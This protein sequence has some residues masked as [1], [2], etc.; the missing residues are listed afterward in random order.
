[1][2]AKLETTENK[3]E[4]TFRFLCPPERMKK[5]VSVREKKSFKLRWFFKVL[6]FPFVVPEPAMGP[7]DPC[8]W[9]GLA[10]PDRWLWPPFG[11]GCPSVMEGAGWAASSGAFR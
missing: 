8:W 11:S 7:P 5:D 3:R 2:S 4:T 9:P 6:P 1:M 10:K